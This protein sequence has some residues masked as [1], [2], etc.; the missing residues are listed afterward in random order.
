MKKTAMKARA[1]GKILVVAI[2]KGG[3]AK[4][5]AARHLAWW[6]SAR[7][8]MKT[9]VV[10]FDPQ[11]NHTTSCLHYAAANGV[12]VPEV[13]DKSYAWLTTRGLLAGDTTTKPLACG[14][15]LYLIAADPSIGDT[16]SQSFSE[17][18]EMCQLRLRALAQEFELIVI[19]TSP[20][21][22]K[23]LV[24]ALAAADFVISPCPPDRD[25]IE[26][27]GRLFNSI[28][29][30]VKGEDQ[31]NPGLVSLGV[32][33]TRV[34]KGRAY[35]RAYLE[36]IRQG[37]GDSV[38]PVQLHERAALELAKDQPVWQT[39]KGTSRSPAALE[40]EEVCTYVFNR[41]GL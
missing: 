11:F 19:D 27:L 12:V 32:L 36:E 5:T 10:D 18:I 26:G 33:P 2:E 21:I 6:G 28:N 4:T 35:H 25:A 38:M 39:T 31:T 17:I 7:R 24:G 1:S 16:E 34:V 37:L 3:A 9:L 29:E 14:N 8:N 13:T 22:S 40:M 30:I 20:S 15:N 41:M 23:M